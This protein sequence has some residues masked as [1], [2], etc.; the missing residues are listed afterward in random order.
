L[1]CVISLLQHRSKYSFEIIIANDCSTDQTREAFSN[2]SGSVRAVNAKYNRGFLQNCNTAADDARGKF[3][4]LLNNDTYVLPGWLDELIGTFGL[5]VSVGLVGSKLVYPDGRLQE[6]GAVVWGDGSGWNLGRDSDPRSPHYNFAREV[7]YCSGAAIAVPRSLWQKLGGFDELYSPAYFEDTDLAFRVRQEGY[8][9]IYQPLAQLF[10]FEG[11]SHGTDEIGGIKAYQAVN[12]ERFIRRWC[13]ELAGRHFPSVDPARYYCRDRL[14]PHVLVVDACTPTPDRDSG[15]VDS[16]NLMRMLREFGCHVTFA[17]QSNLLYFSRYTRDLQRIGVECLY[18][19]YVASIESWLAEHGPSLDLVI[20]SRANVA[21]AVLAKVRRWAEHAKVIFNTV[22][23]HFL[24]DTRE[25]ALSGDRRRMAKAGV[26][27]A[28]EQAIAR[29]A[30][31]TLVVSDVEKRLL[32][33]LEPL[34]R[35][36]QLPLPRSIPGRRRGPNREQE[37]VFL[38]S[39]DHSPNRDAVKYFLE[40]IWPHVIQRCPDCRFIIAGAK[41]PQAFGQFASENVILRGYV[42][43]LSVLFERARLSVAPLRY[44]AGQK[45]KIVTSMSFGVPVVASAIAAE[46]MNLEHGREALITTDPITLASHIVDLLEDDVLWQRLSDAA[47]LRAHQT[48]GYDVV[49]EKFGDLLETLAVPVR[50]AH[51]SGDEPQPERTPVANEDETYLRR[52]SSQIAQHA[53]APIHEAPRIATWLNT[54][55]LS[56]LLMDVMGADSVSDIYAREL[57]QAVQRTGLDC[58]VSIG[59]GDASEE[60][61]AVHAAER[62]GLPP[63]RILCLEL[64]E[65]LVRRGQAAIEGQ[66]LAHR[67]EMRVADLNAGLPVEGSVAGFMAH[68][69]LHHIEALETLFDGIA[70]HMHREGAFVTFDMIGRNGHMRWPEVLHPLRE[71]WRQLPSHL[72]FDRSRGSEDT[73]FTDWDCSIEGFEGVRAQDILPLL[74]S[75]FKFEKFLAWGGLTDVFVDRRFGFNFDPDNMED[76]RFISSLQASEARLLEEGRIY[77]TQMVAVMRRTDA[78]SASEA[79]VC[80]RTITPQRS[81]RPTDKKIAIPSLAEYPV[82]IPYTGVAKSD[83]VTLKP[84]DKVLFAQKD[85]TAVSLLRWG[86]EPPQ[87]DF[88]WGY[89]SQSALCLAVTPDVYEL[90]LTTFGYV[91]PGVGEQTLTISVN[92]HYADTVIHKQTGMGKTALMTLTPTMRADNVLTITIEASRPRRPDID[93]GDDKRPLSIGLQSLSARVR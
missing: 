37:I 14:G 11:A 23:L 30:D 24:R 56:P 26:T 21:D 45:G 16:F 46:G 49:K 43:D 51:P 77:P 44:G 12:R 62:L 47:L 65:I 66:G 53:Q 52:I 8:H 35:I 89:G 15:S 92:G 88:T 48:F 5:F 67:I 76:R 78:Q 81:I 22:D 75:R 84:G 39:F 1:S 29:S 41:L 20:L 36:E 83:P 33:Q 32:A 87:T 85:P 79:A 10:H 2:I 80:F 74:T 3:L 31:V 34:A 73:W 70:K 18:A 58:V 68:H 28:I 17:P 25:A 7:D 60:I 50:P 61:G 19:P 9:V 6:A 93:G 59:A 38:G 82:E 4:V 13:K 72:R 40:A 57:A 64:S 55:F 63:F 86:W 71:I 54:N 91:A 27:Q 69:S 90:E 42:P